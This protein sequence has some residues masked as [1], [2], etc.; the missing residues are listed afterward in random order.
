MK[1]IPKHE[2]RTKLDIYIVITITNIDT[3]AGALLVARG[4]HLSVF[5]H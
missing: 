3:S 5:L 2:M 1:V 4:Y